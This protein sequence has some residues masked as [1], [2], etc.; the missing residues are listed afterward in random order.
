MAATWKTVR[1]FISSTFRDMH[2]ER[3]HLVKVVFPRLRQWCGQRRLHLV[4]IDLRWGVTKEDADNGKA[5]E[6]C[7]SEIDGCRPFF[8]CILGSRYGWVPDE[9][10]PEEMYRFRGLQAETHLSIT[11]LEIQHAA[12]G[13]LSRID[14][15]RKPVCE[16]VFFYFRDPGCLPDPETLTHL[17]S[18]QREEYRRTFFELPP[19]AGHPDRREMLCDLKEE[20]I[21]PRF[22]PDDRVFDYSGEWDRE[23]NNPEDD[24]LIGR[25]T[26][27]EAFGRRVEADVV[28]GI[29]LQFKEHLAALGEKPDP[30]QEERSLHE[31]FIADR[32]QVHVPRTD[33]EEQLTAYVR[34]DDDRPL[35]LTGPPGSGKSAILAHW[36][37]KHVDLDGDTWTAGWDGVTFVV[38]RFIGASASS[39]SLHRL[40]E[41]VCRELVERF[42]LQEEVEAQTAGGQTTTEIRTMEVP[43]DPVEL[44][45]KWP[46]FLAAAAGQGPLLLVLDAVNQ[47]DAPADSFSL[48]WLPRELPPGMKLIVSVLDHGERSRSE[49][50]PTREEPADWLRSLRQI[51]LASTAEQT[52]LSV[53]ELDDETCRKII[54]DLPSVFCKRLEKDQIDLLL[55][56]EATRNPLVAL[57]ELRVFG[58]FEKLPGKI[59]DLPRIEP[60]GTFVNPAAAEELS[61]L[62]SSVLGVDP[63]ASDNAEE[64]R[65]QSSSDDPR[66]AHIDAALDAVFGQVLD[67]LERETDRQTPGLVPTLF[68][69]LASA[70]EGL[71]EQELS[72]LLARHPP[73]LDQETRDGAMQIVLRQLRRYLMRKGTGQTVLVD[74]YHRSFWKAVRARYLKDV[75]ARHAAHG[76]L[77]AYFHDQEWWLETLDQQQARAARLPATPRPANLRKA[78]E[79][80]AQRLAVC[81]EAKAGALMSHMEPAYERLAALFTDLE[82][83]EAKNAAGL[84]F[85]LPH[86]FSAATEALPE[87]DGRRR[88]LKL[89][90][91]ALRRD[92]HFIARHREDYPQGL[93]QCLWNTCWWYDSP[94]AAE[95]YET[96]QAPGARPPGEPSRV[97]GRVPPEREAPTLYQLLE[98]WLHEKE[99]AG[100]FVWLRSLRPPPLHLGT[101]QRAVLRGHERE[102]TGVAYSPDRRRIVSGSWDDTV[103]VWDAESAVEL[104]CF[105]GHE[106]SVESVAYSPDGRR[107]VSGGGWRDKTVRVWDAESGAEM[108]CLRGHEDSVLS[109]AYSPDGWRIVSGSTDQTVRMWDAESG[110]AWR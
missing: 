81:R 100:R 94:Q 74:F 98:R 70:R 36:I 69:L 89:L 46:K 109:V 2:A 39:T 71:S 47:L 37:R 106:Y 61:S 79:L 20:T 31:A 95:H 53:P 15:T 72:E 25:L 88:I 3:D 108:A 4:D 80:P 63:E 28:R 12:L 14:G 7:L 32:T 56:N 54:H 10:A 18:A 48:A 13:P 43:P 78:V 6:I 27:L 49:H 52:E 45:Q 57:E 76:D 87:S 103:R 44:R 104:A 90:D 22:A 58:S 60:D 86:D 85:E 16:Q 73:Q 55:K 62:R 33:A 50:E 93:F 68:K 19:Q 105:R 66:A 99:A 17:T 29:K 8:L 21:R 77:A 67:R 96:G 1:L 24:Q 11:H 107:I 23:A 51:G 30:L 35:V 59:A 42:V 65:A 64:R 102:V 40:M 110:N 101:A 91:E 83:L 92:I 75:A 9:L 82:F 26:D 5:I 41:N 97:S 84:V 34:G 38:P